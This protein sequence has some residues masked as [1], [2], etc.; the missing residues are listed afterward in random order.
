MNTT[1]EGRLLLLALVLAEV[2]S[3]TE[4]TMIYGAMRVLTR[5]FGDPVAVGWSI[6]TLLLVAAGSA[7]VGS[8]LGDQ[9]GRRR[10]LLISLLLTSSPGD[11]AGGGRWGVRVAGRAGVGSGHLVA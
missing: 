7:A 10:L 11:A 2:V 5:D 9:Y 4:A 3:A 8:R 1:A 6:T